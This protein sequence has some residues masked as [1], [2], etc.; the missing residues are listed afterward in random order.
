MA[1]FVLVVDTSLNV[2]IASVVQDLD[3]TVSGVQSAIALEALVSAAFI[4]LGGKVGDLI[5]RKRA[6]VLGL[7]GCAIGAPA[8]AFAQSPTP[9]CW[10]RSP[11]A[12]PLWRNRALCPGGDQQRVAQR[13][14]D[15]AQVMANTQLE[16]LADDRTR[17]ARR[18][19]DVLRNAP[20]PC[21]KAE[22]CSPRRP[23]GRAARRPLRWAP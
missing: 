4:L 20:I 15:D 22:L 1:T 9:S 21:R 12:S 11:S 17:S 8:M 3:T 7:L 16:Q 19:T 10:Q 18:S 23:L 5:G 14:E 6:Y 13:L 2:S